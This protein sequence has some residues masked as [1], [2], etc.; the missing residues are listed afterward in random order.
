MI[1]ENKL[2]RI[3]YLLTLE[4]Q[5]MVVHVFF[6]HFPLRTSYSQIKK[7][8]FHSYLFSIQ[9]ETK[10]NSAIS[11]SPSLQSIRNGL[12]HYVSTVITEVTLKVF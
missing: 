5:W 8:S 2:V 1:D 9:T 10:V 12:F 3:Q 6:T 4:Y 7:E 11:N